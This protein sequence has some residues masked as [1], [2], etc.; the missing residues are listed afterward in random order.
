MKAPAMFTVAFPDGCRCFHIP[1][2]ISKYIQ[3]LAT[4]TPSRIP[5]TH[6]ASLFCPR[7]LQLL[8]LVHKLRR[9]RLGHKLPLVRLLHKVL[10]P[11]LIR[12]VDRVV[13]GDEIEVGALHEVGARL[14]AHERVLPA[15]AFVQDV[16]V[17]APVVAVPAA[18]LGGGFGGLVDAR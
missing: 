12:E 4:S 1:V 6:T 11:L 3:Y 2:H 18:G 15:V 8:R 16:P 7:L 10:V 13:L 5:Y 17:H 9:I 14:P